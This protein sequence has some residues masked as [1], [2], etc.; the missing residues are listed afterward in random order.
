MRYFDRACFVCGMLQIARDASNFF[1][2][3]L[4]IVEKLNWIF[5]QTASLAILL[6][7]RFVVS[8]SLKISAPGDFL[9]CMVVVQI[10]GMWPNMSS[11]VTS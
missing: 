6:H 3:C 11:E 1:P 8:F 10:S 7:S 5:L 2:I 4:G 9:G